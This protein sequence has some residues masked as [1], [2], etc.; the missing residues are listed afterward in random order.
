M[1]EV[2][3]TIARRRSVRR[4]TA[5]Q[6]RRED[7]EAVVEAGL[8]APSANNAQD[9]HFTV[10]QD[11]EMI[12]RIERWVLEEI[13][14]SGNMALQ[15]LV[16]KD[17]SSIFRKAPTLIVVSTDT[18]SRNGVVDAAAATQNM[19]IA[20]ESL[21]IASC[22]IGMVSMLSGSLVVADHARELHLPEGYS[23]YFGITLGYGDSPRPP[24]PERG[25]GRV[26]FFT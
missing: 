16:R 12:A 7:V 4:F 5:E 18:R 9:C 11:L 2:L 8:C 20:A 1:N 24:A 21:G 19:L 6:L 10:V 22:W 26:S 17:G 15:E 23:P 14:R 13:G 25:K 3:K